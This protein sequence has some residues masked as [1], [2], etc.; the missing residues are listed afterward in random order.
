MKYL[1]LIL[2]LTSCLSAPELPSAQPIVSQIEPELEQIEAK[3]G[4]EVKPHVEN[5]RKIYPH[6]KRV[7]HKAV[8]QNTMERWLPW[9]LA[10]GSIAYF[11]WGV[12][13]EDIEDTIGGA[14]GLLFSITLSVFFTEA[15][16]FGII[17][18][19]L[20]VVLWWAGTRESKKI[21]IKKQK[22]E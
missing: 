6:I 9:V 7:E 4:P 2:L 1:V 19:I 11:L 8:E 15:A 3:G 16:L 20:F 5:I 10:I 12:K 21:K 17:V 18:F 13:T 14:I 22:N